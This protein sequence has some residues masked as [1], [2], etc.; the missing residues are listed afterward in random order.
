LLGDIFGLGSTATTTFYIPPKVEWLPA[1]KGKGLEIRGTF[2]RKN[3][4]IYMD[5]TV[6]NKAM[7][8]MNGFG[9]QVSKLSNFFFLVADEWAKLNTESVPYKPFHPGIIFVQLVFSVS[10]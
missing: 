9:I 3:G 5:M 10:N 7:Q 4:T 1:S 6:S 2:S 8:L